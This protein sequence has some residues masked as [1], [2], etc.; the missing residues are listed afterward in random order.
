MPGRI[1]ELEISWSDFGKNIVNIFSFP[2]QV[3]PE[4]F[5]WEILGL[6]LEEGG[7]GRLYLGGVIS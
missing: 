1:A 5:G 2:K 4:N 6:T 7:R 3:Q